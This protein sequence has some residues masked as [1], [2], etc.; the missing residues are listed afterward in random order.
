MEEPGFWDSAEKSQNDV[1]EL[2]RLKDV[3]AEYNGLKQQYEDIATLIEMGYEEND[4]S[5]IPEISQELDTFVE[6]FERLRLD[7]LLSG[8]YDGENA[9]LTL[10]AGGAV[11]KAAT[12]QGCSAVCI[13][14]GPIRRASR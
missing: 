3:I 12:G 13:R 10:H 1:K 2:K 11:R 7:T 9:I 8:E 14:G 4:A 5:L 6:N